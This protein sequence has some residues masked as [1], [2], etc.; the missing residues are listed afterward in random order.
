MLPS[1]YQTSHP[2]DEYLL[3]SKE[4]DIYNSLWYLQLPGDK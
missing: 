3:S 4:G 1:Y 2:V